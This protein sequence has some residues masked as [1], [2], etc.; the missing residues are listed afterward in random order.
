MI[1]TDLDIHCP[2]VRVECN[3]KF[4]A[5]LIID[6]SGFILTN[7]LMPEKAFFE[8]SALDIDFCFNFR[9]LKSK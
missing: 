5:H 2:S 6:S 9:N 7:V 3:L 4:R 8:S 1:N